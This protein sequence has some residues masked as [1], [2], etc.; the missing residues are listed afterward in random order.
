MTVK[1]LDYYMSLPYVTEIRPIPVEL[2]AGFDASIPVFGEKA[3]CGWG[4]TVQNAYD[5]CQLSKKAQIEAY[6]ELGIEIP[7]PEVEDGK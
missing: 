4:S 3:C 5:C 7:E 2:G 6:L 1:D